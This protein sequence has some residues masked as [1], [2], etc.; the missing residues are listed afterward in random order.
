MLKTDYDFIERYKKSAT[1]KESL[2]KP[3]IQKDIEPQTEVQKEVVPQLEPQKEVEHQLE[4][5]KEAKQE[6]SWA[7]KV[8]GIP[9][10]PKIIEDDGSQK[11]ALVL[12]RNALDQIN[13]ALHLLQGVKKPSAYLLLDKISEISEKVEEID[14][15]TTSSEAA[16]MSTNEVAIDT[17]ENKSVPIDHISDVVEDVEEDEI[18]KTLYEET[19]PIRQNTEEEFKIVL[20]RKSKNKKASTTSSMTLYIKENE[21]EKKDEFPSLGSSFSPI[22]KEKSGFWKD[23]TKSLEIAKAIAHIPSPSPTSTPSPFAPSPYAASPY[24]KKSNRVFEEEECYSDDEVRE[25]EIRKRGDN[26]FWQ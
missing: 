1:L 10:P 24:L 25:F 20:P 21:K 5:Q 11:S 19:K 26:E 23:E 18:I 7:K 12:I 13:F 4:I 17:A 8:S 3:K 9:Q 15:S 22:K 16:I 14:A 6:D 2:V